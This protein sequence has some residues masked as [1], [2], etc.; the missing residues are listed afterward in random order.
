MSPPLSYLEFLVAFVLVPVAALLVAGPRLAPERRPTARLG[1][2]IIIAMAVAYTTPWDNYLVASG[3]WEY[4]EGSVLWRIGYAPAE[5]YAFIVSQ[6]VLTALWLYRLDL[7]RA[8]RPAGRRARVAGTLAYL[9]LAVAGLA[10]LDGRGFYLGAILAWAA[11]V[12]ALQWAVGG[13]YLWAV[14][15][16][17]VLAVGVPT[18][19][20]WVIDRVAIA[21]GLWRFS[22]TQTTGLTLLGLPVEEATFFLVTNVLVVQGLVLFHWV[23]EDLEFAAADLRRV[24]AGWR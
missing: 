19:Y 9:A 2:T 24:V 17:V 6:A 5:E 16:R 21:W 10:L 13:H 18:L 7:P 3:V 22:A 12:L 4:A 1:M 8:V 20:L 14:R 15:R 11:P 23:V